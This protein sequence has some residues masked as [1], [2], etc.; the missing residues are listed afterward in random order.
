MQSYCFFALD[1]CPDNQ[2]SK[3]IVG[4]F[5]GKRPSHAMLALR[6]TMPGLTAKPQES[7]AA[8]KKQCVPSGQTCGQQ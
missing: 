4:Y 6:E 7:E 5:P 3:G 1:D 2:I 8:E